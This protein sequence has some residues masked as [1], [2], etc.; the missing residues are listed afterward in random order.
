M[1][2]G[3]ETRITDAAN[4]A[5]MYRYAGRHQFSTAIKAKTGYNNIP[6]N[7]KVQVARTIGKAR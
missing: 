1:S 6:E 4:V 7:R 2:T 5:I 3:P